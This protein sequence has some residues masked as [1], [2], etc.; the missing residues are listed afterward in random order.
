[1]SELVDNLKKSKLEREQA[2]IAKELSEIKAQE[3]AIAKVKA[4]KKQK[5]DQE[6]RQWQNDNFNYGIGQPLSYR[7]AKFYVL[8]ARDTV[9]GLSQIE[10]LKVKM[11]LK[12]YFD[13]L[14]EKYKDTIVKQ[15]SYDSENN[16]VS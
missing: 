5:K 12:K 8:L 13:D 1:M 2:R 4:D 11:N 7:L 6:I 16:R 3:D 10:E 9:K 14:D 15:P